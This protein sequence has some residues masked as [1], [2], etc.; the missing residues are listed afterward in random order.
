M[1]F[2]LLYV[3]LMVLVTSNMYTIIMSGEDSC[4]VVGRPHLTFV[5]FFL[6]R[7]VVRACVAA[8]RRCS[9]VNVNINK[10]MLW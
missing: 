9:D 4:G 1:H 5:C 6:T 8:V 2:V 10:L 3:V 7:A